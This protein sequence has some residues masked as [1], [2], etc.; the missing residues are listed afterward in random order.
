VDRRLKLADVQNSLVVIWGCGFLFNFLLIFVQTVRGVFGAGVQ[1]VWGWFLPCVLPTLG[2]SIASA[3][4]A[5]GNAELKT[6]SKFVATLAR[7]ASIFYLA[8]VLSTSLAWPLTGGD[9]LEWFKLSGL[10]LGPLQGI[11]GA[12]LGTVLASK[13]DVN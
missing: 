11:A 10:W 8:T 9:A 13:G 5:K 7:V 1:E 6:V 4:A 3:V 2:L 12:I